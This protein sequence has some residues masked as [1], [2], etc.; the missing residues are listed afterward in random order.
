[1]VPIIVPEGLPLWG[2]I[3]IAVIVVAVLILYVRHY[4]KNR[5][6]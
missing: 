4:V 2:K 3:V 1:M 5:R 6:P